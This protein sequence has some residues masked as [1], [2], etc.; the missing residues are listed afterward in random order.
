MPDGG[1]Q[2]DADITRADA[3]PPAS[4]AAPAGDCD[5]ITQSGCAPDEKCSIV[6]DADSSNPPTIGCVANVGSIAIHQTCTKATAT[7]PDDCKRGTACVGTAAPRCVEFCTSD[8]A[9]TC[10]GGQVCAVALDFDGD[11]IADAE[12][13]AE[14]CDPLAQDCSVAADACYPSRQEALCFVEGAG[15]TPVAEGGTCDFANSC[16]A[17]NGCFRLGVSLEWLCFKLCD[18]LGGAPACTGGKVCSQ[19]QDET[20][21]ICVD[22]L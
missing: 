3:S 16:A 6:P 8:S 22:P 13:C 20:W 2:V 15:G 4:D 5:P 7:V 9:D 11:F 12:F 19:V 1:P 17:G 18:P 14:P 10:S 21:G